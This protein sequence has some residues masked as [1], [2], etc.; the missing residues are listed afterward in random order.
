MRRLAWAALALLLSVAFFA[1]MFFPAEKK[2]Q[3]EANA[4]GRPSSFG[5][6]SAQM[7]DC[8][9]H[10]AAV[11][12]LFLYPAS[13][14]KV[15]FS[16]SELPL[17]NDFV[18]LSHPSVPGVGEGIENG[19]RQALADCGISAR[20]ANA[21]SAL[22][23]KNA[24][25]ISSAGALPAELYD[26]A[27]ALAENNSRVVAIVALPGRKISASGEISDAVGESG[28]EIVGLLVGAEKS[29]ARQAAR[30]ALATAGN[31]VEEESWEGERTLVLEM[32][33]SQVYCR[34]AYFDQNG[35]CRFAETGLLQKPSG[36]L[37]GR[38]RAVIGAPEQFEISIGGNGE[39]GGK[40]ELEAL[41]I[42][43][44][45]EIGRLAIA[46]GEIGRG[47]AGIFSVNF[48]A[49]GP[50]LVRVEDQFGRLLAQAYVEVLGLKI[51]PVLRQK[52]R[53]EFAASF[54]GKPLDG[55]VL[56]WLED[57]EK[58]QFYSNGG[59][60]VVWA[61]PAQTKSSMSFE[62]QGVVK[63]LEYQTGGSGLLET[64][65]G[66]G[67]PSAALLLA[68][69]LL[70]RARRKT[71]YSIVFP[72]GAGGAPRI[73]D[74]CWAEICSAYKAADA[75]LGGHC[76]A[77]YP[78]E[79]AWQLSLKKGAKI[80]AHS[81]RRVLAKLVEHGKLCESEGAFVPSKMTGNFTC[82]QLLAMRTLHDVMLERG[83]KFARKKLLALP[84]NRLEIAIFDCDSDA[85]RGMGKL[86]RALLF[87]NT[88]QKNMFE[89]R[90]S[91]QCAQNSKI[92]LAIENNKLLL[93]CP[94]RSELEAL[95]A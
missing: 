14:G 48:S 25:I 64:Y 27:D 45:K 89:Q 68:V 4:G 67:L 42:A 18:L 92:K 26:K 73:M 5:L 61:G 12:H 36:T 77:V 63:R 66:Y 72:D 6:Y 34:A 37:V 94:T 21:S 8:E 93:A 40:L 33:S 57:G 71:K 28:F 39:A 84:K 69:Y 65:L 91:R 62:Y 31:V 16:C 58:K 85:L 88:H 2:G 74:T 15:V 76:L 22:G 79:I 56:V 81:L 38:A 43:G 86:R 46:E 49:E 50:S 24:L 30:Q 32:N 83:L 1:I 11:L 10:T 70:I 53:H 78:D 80:D 59:K 9:N 60:L 7:A 52:D 44:R 87:E 41:V 82:A 23:A 17:Q 55:P 35:E 19:V 13:S 47:W 3:G 90:L 29:A 54:G 51:T 20:E 95:L 75:R